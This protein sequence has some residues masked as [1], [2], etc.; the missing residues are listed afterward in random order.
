M[1]TTAQRRTG[2]L[3]TG[4]ALAL[5]VLATACSSGSGAEDS[6]GREDTAAS[7]SEAEAD[8][9][10]S[11]QS[12]SSPGHD[13]PEVIASGL[14][15][16]WSVVFVGDTP[17]VSERDSGRLLEISSD[18][19][20]R[21]VAR[22]DEVAATGEAGLH[23]LAVRD[24]ELYAFYAAGD[25]NRIERFD[26]LGEAGSLSLGEPE[27]VLDGLP[28][29]SFHNGG[30]LAFGPDGMLYATLGDT[31]DRDSAQDRQALSGKILRMSPDGEVPED[32]PFDD[33]LV[34]SMGH[35]NPQGIAWDEQGT[36]YASEFG[37]DT[38]DELNVI[39]AG[40]NYGWPE[41]EGGAGEDGAGEGGSDDFTDPVQ[42]WPPSEASPSGMAVTDQ[43]ILIAG[44][45]G[46]RLHEVAFDDL[47]TSTQLWAG[48]HGRLRDVAQAS[49][50][51]LVVA[52]NN[53]DGRGEPGPDDDRLLRFVP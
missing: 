36:M 48:E 20:A 40:G 41:V 2:R 25:E 13:D 33:S 51:S 44:L 12:S 29:G 9:T 1:S 45:R 26:L 32:N 39:E 37:Q 7:A 31:G 38:W 27:T 14:E 15:A 21:E 8:G 18:G 42:Q 43:S 28:T 34:F 24:D 5:A 19:D 22:L 10:D 50:G 4:A 6:N 30:R 11:A 53:T 17:L 35:R 47:S 49:D 23:G 16:P 46:Q 3:L 52:T